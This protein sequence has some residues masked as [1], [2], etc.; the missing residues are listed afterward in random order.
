MARTI[1]TRIRRSPSTIAREI[2]RNGG[3]TNSPSRVRGRSFRGEQR[4]GA[5]RWR[6]RSSLERVGCA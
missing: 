6:P 3:R 5:G 2:A 4:C 1:A